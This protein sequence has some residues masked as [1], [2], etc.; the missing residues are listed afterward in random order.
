MQPAVYCLERA[1]SGHAGLQG[2]GESV[3]GID[4]GPHR[5]LG[6]DPPAFAAAHA[7][8]QRDHAATRSACRQIAEHHADVVFVDVILPAGAGSG[9]NTTDLESGALAALRP[10]LQVDFL[11]AH[12]AAASEPSLWIVWRPV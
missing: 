11:A 12:S 6:R 8:G 9:R 4:K 2:I 7:T 1:R 3:I 5:E 10:Q